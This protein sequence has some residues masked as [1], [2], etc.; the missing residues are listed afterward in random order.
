M[1][2]RPDLLGHWEYLFDYSVGCIGT[3]KDWLVRAL[4]LALSEIDG[5]DVGGG[6]DGSAPVAGVQTVTRAHLEKTALPLDDCHNIAQKARFGEA[7]LAENPHHV[8]EL[9]TYVNE[10]G[11]FESLTI[12]PS[13]VLMPPATRGT[14]RRVGDRNPTRDPIGGSRDAG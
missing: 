7:Q 12:D 4:T 5:G 3:L 1:A 11:Q 14:R 10:R 6:K 2:N 13:A 8:T 9:Q